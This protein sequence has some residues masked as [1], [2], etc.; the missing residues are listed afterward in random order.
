MWHWVFNFGAAAVHNPYRVGK[1]LGAARLLVGRADRDALA[2]G[3]V[4]NFGACQDACTK[5]HLA[6]DILR[7]WTRR[8][9]S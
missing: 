7:T 3:V 6:S 1:D 9:S 8:G 2:N 4:E 5:N